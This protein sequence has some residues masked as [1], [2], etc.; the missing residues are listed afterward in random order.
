MKD[1]EIE[2]FIGK[3]VKLTFSDKEVINGVLGKGYLH[4]NCEWIGKGYHLIG[5]NGDTYGFKKSHIK[6]IEVLN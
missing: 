1:V 6:K 3:K 4:F 5:N 2:P